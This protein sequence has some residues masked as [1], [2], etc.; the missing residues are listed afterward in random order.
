M[1]RGKMGRVPHKPTQP[2]RAGP[3]KRVPSNAKSNVYARM[4]GRRAPTHPKLGMTACEES[5]TLSGDQNC[6]QAPSSVEVN[7]PCLR[8]WVEQKPPPREEVF[9]I[10][11]R[12]SANSPHFCPHNG[13]GGGPPYPVFKLPHKPSQPEGAGSPQRCPLKLKT[14]A[15]ARMSGGRAPTHPKLGMTACEE[16]VTLSGGQN[17]RQAPSNV[18]VNRLCLRPW[19]E[20]KKASSAEGGCFPLTYG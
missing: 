17:C 1:C 16:R 10:D 4:S 19:V 12:P 11:I 9:P 13:T 14:R 15:Y 20:A 18:E 6:R 7:R 2:E 5:V 3:H 8:P